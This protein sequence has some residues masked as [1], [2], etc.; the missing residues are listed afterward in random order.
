MAQLYT[1]GP[2]GIYVG[3]S[4]NG[5]PVFLGHSRRRPRIRT[6]R[7]KQPI[8]TDLSGQAPHD[9]M[10][11]GMMAT[12]SCEL[13]RYNMNV[14][15]SI[16]DLTGARAEFGGG[17]TLGSDLPGSIGA[18]QNEEDFGYRLWVTFPH[19]GKV[20]FRRAANGILPAGYLFHSAALDDDDVEVGFGPKTI[21]V[22]WTC[23]YRFNPAFRS[24]VGQGQF[25][26]F[27]AL[28]LQ[29]MQ[30]LPAFT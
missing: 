30:A 20:R 13:I 26:L 17:A 3:I 2:A 10:F 11:G 16:R 12:V 8:T 4:Q 25:N 29:Q 15:Q 7:F 9:M 5:N 22:T 1:T 27:T 28:T 24:A 21:Q 14:L 23:I 19:A 18:L 6:R